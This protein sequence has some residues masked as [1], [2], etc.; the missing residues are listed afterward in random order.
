[1]LKVYP[2]AERMVYEVQSERHA[3]IRY[4]CDLLANGGAG[5]CACTDHATRRQVALDE[6]KE[7]LTRATTCKHLAAAHRHF[8]LGFLQSLAHSEESSS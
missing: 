4:R 2:T 3:H 1:M 7:P 6:G 8:L 5:R